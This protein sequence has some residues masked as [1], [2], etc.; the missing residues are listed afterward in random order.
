MFKCLQGSL[1]ANT[2]FF[3]AI[4]AP[5]STAMFSNTTENLTDNSKSSKNS[6]T[7]SFTDAMETATATTTYFPFIL[8]EQRIDRIKDDPKLNDGSKLYS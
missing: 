8:G 1:S 4:E 7:E 6:T 5:S 2:K 3:H